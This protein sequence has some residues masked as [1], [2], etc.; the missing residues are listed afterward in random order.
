MAKKLML[1]ISCVLLLCI[2][3][4]STAIAESKNC[5]NEADAYCINVDVKN[6]QK[7]N[8]F[9]NDLCYVLQI[10]ASDQFVSG[11]IPMSKLP[12]AVFAISKNQGSSGK[13]LNFKIIKAE[14]VPSGQCGL[15]LG[16][17][18][19]DR[20]EIF[21]YATMAGVSRSILLIKSRKTASFTC[22]ITN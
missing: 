20:C 11:S 6:S 14:I 10:N 13:P 22:D 7:P 17:A 1:S 3:N 21:E 15:N 19:V 2:L 9:N 12:T 5:Q 16:L 8:N 4:I 18:Q